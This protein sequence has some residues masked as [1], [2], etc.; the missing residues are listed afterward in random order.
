MHTH[1][2]VHILYVYKFAG[3]FLQLR[4]SDVDSVLIQ[5]GAQMTF[6][7]EVH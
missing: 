1:T 6:A 2:C 7:V 5:T 3:A 4:N